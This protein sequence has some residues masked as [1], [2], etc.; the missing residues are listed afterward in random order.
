M[1][2]SASSIRP[3]RIAARVSK[4]AAFLPPPLRRSHDLAAM[5]CPNRS[6]VSTVCGGCSASV[7]ASFTIAFGEIES[8]HLSWPLI[9]SAEMP[10]ATLESL[11]L[12]FTICS[13]MTSNTSS[14]LSCCCPC[15][16]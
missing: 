10:E 13:V 15:G 4:C 3:A 8:S 1:K 7:A 12:G 16:T 14:A 5:A 6:N 2:S 11:R 9:T